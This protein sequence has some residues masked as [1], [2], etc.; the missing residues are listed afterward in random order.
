MSPIEPTTLA[1]VSKSLEAATLRQAV[2]ARNL[3]NANTEDFA[4]MQVRFEEHLQQVR[5]VLARG[6][7]VGSGDLRDV[8]ASIASTDTGTTVELDV[9]VAALARNALHYQVLLKALDREMSLMSLAV[10]DGRR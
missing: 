5:D 8:Q 3:A 1:L 10:A 9:E 4:P 2:H 7:Q 6:G